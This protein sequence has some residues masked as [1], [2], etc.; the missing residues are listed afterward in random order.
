MVLI[1]SVALEDVMG[2]YADTGYSDAHRRLAKEV[3]HLI[4]NQLDGGYRVRNSIFGRTFAFIKW[5][6]T[7]SRDLTRGATTTMDLAFMFDTGLS[8][9]FITVRARADW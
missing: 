8:D 4:A 2:R 7:L 3:P 9:S 1:P 6:P 5:W